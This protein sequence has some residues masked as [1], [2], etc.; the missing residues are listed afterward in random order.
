MKT[1]A[2]LRS[3]SI[4]LCVC[5][6][7]GTFYDFLFD[8]DNKYTLQAP[9]SQEGVLFLQ[10]DTQDTVVSLV[11]GWELYPDV[12][13]DSA[14]AAGHTPMKAFIGQYP[15]F[16]AFHSD[17]SP[18]GAAT[19]RLRLSGEHA[20][21]EYVLLFTEIFSA[22]RIYVNG[23]LAAQAG[24]LAPY[25]PV[26]KDLVIPLTVCGETEILVHTVNYTHYYSGIIYPPLLGS[27]EAIHRYS[28]LH[29]LFYAFLCFSTLALTAFSAAIWL[30]E[31][32]SA[33]HIS[34]WFAGLAFCFALRVCYPFTN[35]SGEVALRLLYFL[36]DSAAAFSIWCALHIVLAVYCLGEWRIGKL[37]CRI[38]L[39]AALVS[40]VIPFVLPL[41]P[42]FTTLWGQLIYCYRL[43]A[44]AGLLVIAFWGSIQR[45]PQSQWLLAGVGCYASGLLAHA[46][47]LGRFEPAVTGWQEEYGGFF[48]LLC[49]AVVVALRSY[50][51]VRENTHLRCHLQEEVAEKTK[52]LQMVLEERRHFLAGAMHDLK[53]PMSSI[54][55]FLQLLEEGNIGTNQELWG[56][57]RAIEQKNTELQSKLVE[58]QNFAAEDLK[59]DPVKQLDLAA[60]VEK[61]QAENLPD[62][63]VAGV[64]LTLERPDFPC[65]V[66][67]GRHRLE[68]VLQNI[69]Y[70]A[71]SFTPEDGRIALRVLP[72]EGGYTVAI[73]DNGC[74]ISPE[75]LPHIFDR[76]FSRRED[77]EST[78]L[79]LYFSRL[80]VEELGGKIGVTSQL[81]M[82]CTFTFWLPA[83]RQ[84][85]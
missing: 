45:K 12:L 49:F 6:L 74:G 41:L 54:R 44:G 14:T 68:Q 23:V 32:H 40:A 17:A 39:H 67:A 36:E 50:A 15:S 1:Y 27:A 77:G 71:L 61:F 57:L 75:D 38:T 16:A 52:S 25:A 20:P 78:G 37:L 4:L 31:R 28:V 53:A 8:Y 56:Y 82:G 24:S 3:F 60:L 76:F 30:G 42:A 51:M 9:I 55:I 43:L 33:Q 22:C 85:E 83:Y 62:M 5:I 72:E 70:N 26:V 73:A 84:E 69:V 34:L 81:G 7:S 65:M 63:D 2:W 35:A 66:L 21:G 64:A 80:T 58:I 10:E 79:G 48:F 47:T 59:P 18:Y 13:L 29:T 11:N 19:Y 46:L